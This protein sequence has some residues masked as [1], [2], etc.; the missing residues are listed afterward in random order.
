MAFT[1]YYKNKGGG[2]I[3]GGRWD[4]WGGGRGEMETTVL[5]Q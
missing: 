3:K 4:G 5:E 1:L 2:R